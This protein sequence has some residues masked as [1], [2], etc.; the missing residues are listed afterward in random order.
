MQKV[1][2]KGLRSKRQLTAIANKLVS[3]AGFADDEEKNFEITFD[4]GNGRKRD[5]VIFWNQ[6]STYLYL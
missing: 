4:C 3:C 6:K 5:F 1:I 2:L